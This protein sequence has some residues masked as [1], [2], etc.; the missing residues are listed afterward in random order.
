MRF[1]GHD[2]PTRLEPRDSGFGHDDGRPRL[3][4]AARHRQQRL[5][6]ALGQHRQV[7]PDGPRRGSGFGCHEQCQPFAVRRREPGLRYRR[8]EQS[9]RPALGVRAGME[10][11][12]R[13]PRE[14]RRLVRPRLQRR[15]RPPGRQPGLPDQRPLHRHLG[16]PHGAS[17]PV[18]RLRGRLCVQGRRTARCLRVRQLRGWQVRGQRARRAP[19]AVLGA[20]PV[21][22]R[23][24][25]R[26]RRRDGAHR[27]VQGAR[28]ARV[29]SQGALP[30]DQQAVGF[31]PGQFQP[32]AG[33][34]LLP[35]VGADALCRARQLLRAVRDL[36][37][38][39]GVRHAD[40]R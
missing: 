25:Q 28:G 17:G 33:G 16:L 1:A 21:R 39:G 6:G 23:R 24:D 22:F 38:P 20:E 2:T 12:F 29:G 27:S 35:R 14:W 30:A 3:G 26:H 36:D 18:Q 19:H 4:H 31:V 9:P 11:E 32:V 7:Q 5:R 13:L 15:Q 34:L 37:G 10:E 8:R 40:R